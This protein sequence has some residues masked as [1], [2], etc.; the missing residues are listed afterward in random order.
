[1]SIEYDILVRQCKRN[2]ERLIRRLGA[3]LR[4]DGECML[5]TGAPSKPN[6]YGKA[7]FWQDGKITQV[8]VHRLF[9]T[10]RLCRPIAPDMEAG[11]YKCFNRLC[12]VHV[13]EQ[14]RA[15]NLG[16]RYRGNQKTNNDCPF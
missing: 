5:W 7:N 15:E 9:L 1:M 4:R 3:R 11:H 13:E 10:L 16:L 12:V 14:T 6:G 2:K 8:Y